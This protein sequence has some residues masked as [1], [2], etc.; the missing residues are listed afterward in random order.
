MIEQIWKKNLNPL[1]IPPIKLEWYHKSPRN[2][3]ISNQLVTSACLLW[4]DIISEAVNFEPEVTAIM[5]QDLMMIIY[6][7]HAMASEI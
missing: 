6:V 1:E 3:F 5:I 7:G 2:C 4:Q